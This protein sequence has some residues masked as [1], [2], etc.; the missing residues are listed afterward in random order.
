LKNRWRQKRQRNGV[1][2]NM[3]MMPSRIPPC[4]D[5]RMSRLPHLGHRTITEDSGVT[6]TF[7]GVE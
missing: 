6:A 7:L 2:R 1:I 3:V 4:K 5:W